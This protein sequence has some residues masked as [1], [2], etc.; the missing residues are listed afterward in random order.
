MSTGAQNGGGIG[1][2]IKE[3]IGLYRT[4]IGVF[5]LAVA[6]LLIEVA[7]HPYLVDTGVLAEGWSLILVTLLGGIWIGWTWRRVFEAGDWP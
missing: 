3:E 1:Y 6:A 2:W 5:L 4:F 7:T